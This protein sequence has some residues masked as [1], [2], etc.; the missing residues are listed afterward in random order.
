MS[1]KEILETLITKCKDC[2]HQDPDRLNDGSDCY[3]CRKGH[4]WKPDDWFCA[5]GEP[6]DDAF[7]YAQS[8]LVSTF[9]I[10]LQ[11]ADMNDW[12]M[13]RFSCDKEWV[14]IFVKGMEE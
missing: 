5:D 11:I 1:N 6:K 8:Q 9:R 13:V 7:R 14:R 12:D 10:A 2:K 4:G 3:V